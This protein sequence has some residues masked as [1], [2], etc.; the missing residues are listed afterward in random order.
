MNAFID[1]CNDVWLMNDAGA[2]KLISTSHI[3]VWSDLPKV[4]EIIYDGGGRI[5]KP[6][7]AKANK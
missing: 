7:N 5:N 3:A 4:A 2:T 1:A 6:M